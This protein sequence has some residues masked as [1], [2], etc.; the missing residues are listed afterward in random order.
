MI[1]H[2]TDKFLNIFINWTPICVVKP[3]SSE[4]GGER[5]RHCQNLQSRYWTLQVQVDANK[6]SHIRWVAKNPA[7]EIKRHSTCGTR[8]YKTCS[9][10]PGLNLC[11]CLSH[12]MVGGKG[13]RR[14]GGGGDWFVPKWENSHKSQTYWLQVKVYE[15]GN[16]N[17]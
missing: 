9:L 1:T 13:K 14:R 5:W 7:L 2:F 15:M 12:A 17:V 4:R 10:R 16:K 8:C 11:F 3:K 6:T